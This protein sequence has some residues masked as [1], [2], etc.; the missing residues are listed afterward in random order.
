MLTPF[1]NKTLIGLAELNYA[2][3]TFNYD[4]WPSTSF[5]SC[6]C[7]ILVSIEPFSDENKIT[8]DT[9]RPTTIF[10]GKLLERCVRKIGS[11][12]ND[13]NRSKMNQSFTVR[14]I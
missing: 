7:S 1:L 5:S 9:G 12:K 11:P 10:P 3:V 14:L 2:R 13:L 4:V 8:T 6:R